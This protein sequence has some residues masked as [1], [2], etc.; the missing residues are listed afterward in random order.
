MFR[1][2]TSLLVPCSQTNPIT[3]SPALSP[4]III[5]IIVYCPSRRLRLVPSSI[6]GGV[7]GGDIDGGVG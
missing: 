2:Q 5:I 1:N 3:I 4:R 6:G 7:G